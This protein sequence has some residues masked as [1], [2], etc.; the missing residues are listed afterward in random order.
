MTEHF[1]KRWENEYLI[2]L[3][4]FHKV[5][6]SKKDKQVN[7]ITNAGDVVLIHEENT[8]KM[9]FKLSTIDSFKPSRDS[10]KRIENV[11]YLI[12]GKLFMY[13]GQ[14]INFVQ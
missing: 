11:H 6:S 7:Q 9:I 3:R 12:N 5:K 2:E 4:E 13:N 10:A 14:L 8:T 1:T